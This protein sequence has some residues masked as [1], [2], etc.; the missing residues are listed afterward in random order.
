[1]PRKKLDSIPWPGALVLAIATAWVLIGNGLLPG[2]PAAFSLRASDNHGRV[3]MH[4]DPAV[5]SVRKADS[6]T[7]DALDEGA[8]T[9]YPIETNILQRG[10][11]AYVRQQRDVALTFTLY[12]NGQPGERV[13]VLSIGPVASGK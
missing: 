3:E 7:L 2:R 1:M 13:S 9:R 8:T 11:L 10:A 12:K 6:A 5:E 4:W